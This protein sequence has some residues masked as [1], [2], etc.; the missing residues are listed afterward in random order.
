MEF[1]YNKRLGERRMDIVDKYLKD[2]PEKESL[3]TLAKK[4]KTSVKDGNIDNVE[5]VLDGFRMYCFD[6]RVKGTCRVF[7]DSC[8]IFKK[9]KKCIISEMKEYV[10]DNIKVTFREK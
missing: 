6:A 4:I 3:R 5:M 2:N 8:P 7:C 10:M 9:V 1:K